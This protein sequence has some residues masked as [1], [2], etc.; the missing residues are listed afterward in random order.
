MTNL[1]QQQLTD[2]F[3]AL[4]IQAIQHHSA[5][6]VNEAESCYRKLQ[7]IAPDNVAVLNLYGVLSSQTNRPELAR[8]LLAQ[9]IANDDTNANFHYNLANVLL[10]SGEDDKAEAHYRRAL[11]LD[12]EQLDAWVNLG[13]LLCRTDRLTAAVDCFKRAMQ[14]QPESMQALENLSQCLAKLGRDD[15]AEQCFQELL[16]VQPDNLDAWIGLVCVT[17]RLGRKQAALELADQVQ[18]NTPQQPQLCFRLSEMYWSL[19]RLGEAAQQLRY[20]VTLDPD[21]TDALSNLGGVLV[22]LGQYEIAEKVLQ[23]AIEQDPGHINA[24][25]NFASAVNRLGRE[26]EAMAYLKNI[27]EIDP[28]HATAHDNL[29]YIYWESGDYGAA[30]QEFRQ[31]VRHDPKH[32]NAHTNLGMVLLTQGSYAE[33]WQEYAWRSRLTRSL[34]AQRCYE[35]PQWQG[36][37]IEGQTLFIYPEQG[38]GDIFQFIRY[39]FLLSPKVKQLIIEVP[40]SLKRLLAGFSEQA[41]IISPEEPMPEF[42][43][44]IPLL[45]LPSVLNTDH[46]SIPEFTP[47][48]HAEDEKSQDWEQCLSG[49]EGIKVGI[50]WQ[51]NSKNMMDHK[52]SFSLETFRPLLELQEIQYI[53]LQKGEGEDQLEQFEDHNN[54]VSFGEKLDAGPDAFIDT[55]AIIANLDLVI[56]CDSA[57]AHL[58][59]ALGKPVWL[60]LAKVADF[61]W[62]LARTDSPWYPSVRIFRQDNRGDWSS[63][64]ENIKRA[65]IDEYRLRK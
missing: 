25:C 40:K 63:V 33:G 55:A 45:S 32:A 58:A 56:T 10:E 35:Q 41:L 16:Q 61:R 47:Y 22:E 43:K 46:S 3:T 59:G 34:G 7:S 65:L 36:E 2:E 6:H 1:S 5:G 37:A 42:D 21:Y 60:L 51:G 50:A 38:L 17:H 31:A 27:L 19:G 30:E 48:L 57:M 18:Q 28:Q 23:R 62:L 13:V 12:P 64:T 39:V 26:H 15:E 29:G 9:A 44:H 8:Q 14:V 54:L 53:S 20:A 24:C 11:D 4:L 49:F 52:R